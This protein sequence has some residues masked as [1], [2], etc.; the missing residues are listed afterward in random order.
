MHKGEIPV[1]ILLVPF[2]LGL[3]VGMQL[4]SAAYLPI[5]A[6]A[7]ICLSIVF[8]ALNLNYQRLVI[9]KARWIGGLLM[10]MIL[11]SAGWISVISYN[12]LNN[13]HHFS[14]IQ[15][16]YLAV[17]INNEPQ[18]K[19][20][21]VRFTATV[22]QS[23]N[24]RQTADANGTLL[25]TLKDS[26]AIAL[27]YG[28]ELLVPASYTPV[29]PPFNPAEFN[30][31]KYLAHQNIYY[32][33]FL[34]PGQYK[35]LKHNTGNAFIAYA[36][37]LRQQMVV[38]F[39]QKLHDPNAIAVASTLILGYKADLSNDVLQTYSK[40]G[41]IHV[42]SVSGAHV[43][44]IYLLMQ[45]MLS[46]LNRYKYGRHLKM[47]IMILLISYYA[48][49]TGFSPAVC[50]AAVMISMIIIGQTFTRHISMLNILAISALLLL[51]YN[52]FF[53]T[54]VG[55]QLSYLSVVGLIV[56]QPVVYAWFKFKN[57]W[58]DKLW[59]LCSVSIAAQVI[60]F[61]LSAYYFHQFPV[62]F[63]LSNLLI[64]IPTM[65]IMYSGITYLL[66]AWVPGLSTALAW[67][68]E[69]SIL[70][71]NKALSIIE[72]A[73]FA[74]INKIWFTTAEY[75]LTYALI[76]SLFY[77][78][79]DKKSWLLK[80]SMACL[81]LL[82][83]SISVKRYRADNSSSVAFLNLR[84]NTGMVFKNGD[85]AVVLTNLADT[86]KNYKYSIQPYLDS[87]KISYAELYPFD[88]SISK[89]YLKKQGGFIQFNNKKIMVFN[90]QTPS[91]QLPEK[92]K[93]DY[94]YIT[95]NPYIDLNIINKN[96]D[97]QTL[98]IDGSNSGKLID[99]LEQQAR[100]MHIN[101]S[102]LKRNISLIAVS[103]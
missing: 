94:L 22:R 6:I 89:K 69:K 30:Y 50:R 15:A 35:L 40:T 61:P 68:L 78:L 87:C 95:G 72:H 82:C 33:V 59:A 53:I 92:L 64:I 80:L 98:V 4:M 55:F 43:A 28:D 41:T 5:L 66:L 46:F 101:Y 38:L 58:A 81:F 60:T 36:L 91:L 67:V 103:N 77:F 21:L 8:I 34:F 10:G 47:T 93:T 20:G 9:Y 2:L 102:V 13:R 48:M 23:I 76:I 42:L 16:Q 96:Y 3:A 90:R 14:K 83:V 99:Q 51:L 70:L 52:P 24:R 17:S 31:K 74:S 71:M 12:E 100:A 62:Y 37:K 88:Q 86:D 19:N 54:D 39:R 29:D 97:Y 44:I 79:Y 45:W 27:Q 32:Q 85:K 25:L 84:K 57:K 7:F 1:V 63:L 75:L 18:L 49:L 26:D 73:P 11:F 56:L 65:V